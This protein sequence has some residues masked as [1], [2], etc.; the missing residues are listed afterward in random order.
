MR[1]TDCPFCRLELIPRQRVVL[2]N[3]TCMFL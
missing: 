1:P 2:A 3:E